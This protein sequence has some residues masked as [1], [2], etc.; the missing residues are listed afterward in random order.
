MTSNIPQKKHLSM[1]H[2]RESTEPCLANQSQPESCRVRKDKGKSAPKGGKGAPKG[3]KGAPKG[4]KGAPKGA[5][6]GVPKGAPKG[7]PKG[8]KGGKG[9]VPCWFHE[10]GNC[11]EGNKC[12]FSHA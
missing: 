5:P 7:A 12:S 6:K 4:G 8:G 9:D 11:R 3:G 1:V 10:Q 2:G